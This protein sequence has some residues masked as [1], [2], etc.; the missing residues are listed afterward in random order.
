MGIRRGKGR[1]KLLLPPSPFSDL[2]K[3]NFFLQKISIQHLNQSLYCN[4]KG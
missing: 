4:D 3:K 1:G 2:E